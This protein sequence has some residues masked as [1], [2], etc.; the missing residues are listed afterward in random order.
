MINPKFNFFEEFQ[1]NGL[2]LVEMGE[3]YGFIDE[4]GEYVVKPQF[5][6][7]YDFSE[8]VAVVAQGDNYGLI[9]EKGTYVVNPMYPNL[10]HSMVNGRLAFV[11]E[12]GRLGYLD[13]NGEEV[14][15]AQFRCTLEEKVFTG[16]D[17][18]DD[19]YA[20]VR[21][22]DKY[23]VIDKDGNIVINPQFDGLGGWGD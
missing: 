21:S 15:S 23:G 13:Q 20:I 8:G 14:I 5:D 12:R 3:K 17:F 7:A 22:K 10:A 9:D 16:T 4:T 19:G 18:Y 1:E 6:E 2:A 11:N